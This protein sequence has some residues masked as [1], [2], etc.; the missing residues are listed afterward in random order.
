[1]SGMIGYAFCGSFCTLTRSLAELRRLRD[2]GYEL[3]PIMSEHVYSLDTRFWAA[4]AFRDKV[5]DICRRDI[6]HTIIDAEPLGP[7]TPLDALIVA[8]CTGN[9]LAKVAAGITDSAVTM[10]V[11]AHLRC[12]RPTLIALASNDALSQNLH[13]IATVMV[14]K[15]VY[16]VPMKQDDP[17]KKPYSL[18]ADFELIP[19][20]LEAARRGRQLRPIFC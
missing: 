2:A 20:A 6:I 1:M 11:K 19:D 18:I 7:K 12:D 5:T 4:K 13:N 10:A 16:F 3:Q 8:P 9:T 17:E 15:S 14:R